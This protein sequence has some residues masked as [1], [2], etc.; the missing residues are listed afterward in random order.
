[1]VMVADLVRAEA[2]LRAACGDRLR[3][4]MSLAPLTTLRIGG[5]AALYLEPESEADLTAAAHAVQTCELD[6]VV[7]GKVRD[8]YWPQD[9]L[10]VEGDSYAWHRSPDAMADDRQRDVTVDTRPT[11]P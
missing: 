6:V 11:V 2:I 4:S 1:M 10:V 8:F 9:R 7:L 5:P 3:T